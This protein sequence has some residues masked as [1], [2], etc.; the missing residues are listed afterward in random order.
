M[1]RNLVSYVI[2]ADLID[3]RSYDAAK[4]Q[5]FRAWLR[6]VRALQ[7]LDRRKD[8]FLANISHELR[9][10]LVTILGY[11]DLLLGEKLGELAPRQ[12][13]AMQVLAQSGRCTR[14]PRADSASHRGPLNCSVKRA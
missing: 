9:T 11:A 1:G 7:E 4:D 2:A 5:Q 13:A 10:P 3:L 12:H 8:N 14:A 6:A